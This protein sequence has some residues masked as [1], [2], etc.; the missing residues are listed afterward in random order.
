MSDSQSGPAGKL[1]NPADVKR[2]QLFLLAI[3]GIGVLLA[4]F[5]T[6]LFS[7][8]DEKVAKSKKKES[9]SKT[10]IATAA[11][12]VDPRDVWIGTAGSQIAT[13][14][15]DKQGLED[16]IRR[17]EDKE[18]REERPGATA[19][20]GYMPS[21]M[22]PPPMAPPPVALPA[23]APPPSL[24]STAAQ[25]AVGAGQLARPDLQVPMALPSPIATTVVAAPQAAPSPDAGQ[26]P[27]RAGD[28]QGAPAA[29]AISG[30]GTVKPAAPG[31]SADKDLTRENY[32]PAGA[33]FRAVLLS[34]LDAPTG[35]QVQANPHPVL[36][37]LLDNAVLP[38]QFRAQV[39]EC[40]IVAAGYGDM[41]S[42]RAYLR[43]E[44]LSCVN[45]RGQVIDVAING[46]AIGDDG[47]AGIRGQLVSKQG[48]ALANAVLSGVLSGIGSAI[49]ES[50][51]NT[52]VGGF[53]GTVVQ[54][55]KPGQEFR[56]GMGEGVSKGVDRLT[57]YYVKL[58]ERMFPVVEVDA[59]RV[60]DIALS[61]G[62]SLKGLFKQDAPV[63]Q[64]GDDLA[65]LEQRQ[66]LRKSSLLEPEDR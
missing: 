29:A 4:A 10:T 12:K 45:K 11:S 15:K 5:F 23:L 35:G 47:K 48:R 36:L 8:G 6:T 60:V 37:R 64:A 51:V 55:P 21:P 3:V 25:P 50:S 14:E 40:F 27:Q 26:P 61:K 34:G 19:A 9:V 53:S 46:W 31:T 1:E 39:K 44:S 17:L 38:N 62:M 42:E 49:R 43:T 54:T 33:F 63:V 58:A 30:A 32:I 2:K 56:A 18:K 65:A 28:S 13:L 52:Q 41:S 7:D 24:G 66:R 59:G 22:A 16:R 57:D 20:A